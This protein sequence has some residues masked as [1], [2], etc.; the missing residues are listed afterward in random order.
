MQRAILKRITSGFYRKPLSTVP[1]E[2]DVRMQVHEEL[3]KR[4]DGVIC[5]KHIEHD[6]E[7]TFSYLIDSLQLLH[8]RISQVI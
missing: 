5:D 6:N 1:S 4:K 7:L 2:T 3:G 8:D